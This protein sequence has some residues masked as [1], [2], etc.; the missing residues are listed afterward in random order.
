[1][2]E[3]KTKIVED[4]GDEVL[5]HFKDDITA[6]DGAKHD[7]LE[8]KGSICAE[9]TARLMKMLSE[10]GVYNMFLEFVPP[11][12]I[13]ARKLK[14]LPLE[15]I[16]RFKKAG[17]FV[18]RYGG[19]EG[20]D[21]PQPLVEFT[22]KSDALHDP[23]MCVEHLE[24]LGITSR[25]V[26]KKVMDEAVKTATILKE[27]FQGHGYELWDIKFEYGLDKDGNVCLG[28]EISPDT[29][30]LRKS[31]EIFDKDV[32]RRD[33]GDPMER[34]KVVLELCRSISL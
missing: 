27:F 15:V 20:E 32:Y 9:V 2:Y 18:R 3:G 12:K 16:V 11:K 6:G 28:D 23:L 25:E 17:S 24:V 19:T 4:L 13:R 14:M 7:V 33:L 29:M 26:A 31:G 34:Y 1:M 10:K 22:Y 30:R 5:L 21:L 8:N